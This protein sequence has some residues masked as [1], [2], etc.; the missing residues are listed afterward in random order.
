MRAP[1][2]LHRLSP[3]HRDAELRPSPMR[4]SRS[5]GWRISPTARW[6]CPPGRTRRRSPPCSMPWAPSG[7][8]PGIRPSPSVLDDGSRPA[9]R[10]WIP[11]SSAPPAG[12]VFRGSGPDAPCCSP[13]AAGSTSRPASIKGICCT[14]WP[15]ASPRPGSGDRQPRHRHHPGAAV[16]DPRA[17]QPGS[18]RAT[19]RRGHIAQRGLQTRTLRGQGGGVG[20]HHPGSG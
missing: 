17:T 5:A 12:G 4:A 16:A 8:R 13:R 19:A 18:P 20:G 3:L 1:H 11:C 15:I 7:P 2:R 10:I 9:P 6:S 14:A